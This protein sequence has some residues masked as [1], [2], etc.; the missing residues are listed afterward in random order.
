MTGFQGKLIQLTNKNKGFIYRA[1][2]GGIVMQGD[3]KP[4]NTSHHYNCSH[5]VLSKK[6]HYLR[7]Y[8]ILRF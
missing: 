1:N 5:C 6:G 3:T 2:T 8:H 7:I 4:V